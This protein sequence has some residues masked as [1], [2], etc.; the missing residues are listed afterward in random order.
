M[1]G[2]GFIWRNSSTILFCKWTTYLAIWRARLP[3]E[4]FGIGTLLELPRQLFREWY[5]PLHILASLSGIPS[6]ESRSVEQ[7]FDS[8][9]SGNAKAIAN[10][11]ETTYETLYEKDSEE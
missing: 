7:R 6:P 4:K 1:E 10:G 3:I 9:L 2:L 5:P 8:N 11:I